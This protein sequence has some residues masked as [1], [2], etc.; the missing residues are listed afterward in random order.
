MPYSITYFMRI[1]FE[2]RCLIATISRAG[3]VVLLA[4]L[5]GG[6][7]LL[8]LFGHSDGKTSSGVVL[9][10][11]GTYR[12]TGFNTA[13][14]PIMMRGSNITLKQV[15]NT[16]TQV[17]LVMDPM[18][19]FGVECDAGLLL[20]SSMTATVSGDTLNVKRTGYHSIV[21]YRYSGTSA[22]LSG[23]F[24]GEIYS[25]ICGANKIKGTVS[26]VKISG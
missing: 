9:N 26:L 14:T 5:L 12:A 4:S 17:N 18:P 19:G 24:D 23:T 3:V 11:N 8:A 20:A 21:Y 16:V 15:G 2:E 13:G 22:N 25:G 7:P 1:W 10:L 6:C